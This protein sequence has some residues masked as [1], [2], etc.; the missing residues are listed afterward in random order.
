MKVLNIAAALVAVCLGSACSGGG[1]GGG[2][3]AGM[4][5]LTA[6]ADTSLN[7]KILSDGCKLGNTPASLNGQNYDVTLTGS[8]TNIT[9]VTLNGGGEL[10]GSGFTFTQEQ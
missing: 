10:T 5:T 4:G 7:A 1:G 3:P 6:G 9:G 2:D 8:G